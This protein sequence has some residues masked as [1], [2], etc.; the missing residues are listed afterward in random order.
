MRLGIPSPNKSQYQTAEYKQGTSQQ[1][2]LA[3]IDDAGRCM[4][5]LKDGCDN[6]FSLAKVDGRHRTG[7][8]QSR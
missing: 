1:R 8:R 2:L 5:G 4:P 7:K 6:T 3:K